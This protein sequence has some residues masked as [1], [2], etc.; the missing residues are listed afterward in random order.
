MIAGSLRNVFRYSVTRSLLEVELPVDG[1][2]IASTNVSRTPNASK[3]KRS[4]ETAG[5][6]LRR[7][8]GNSP[9]RRLRTLSVC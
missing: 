7:Q 4:S 5:D 8:K 2:L 9:E 1:G 6:K 3:A